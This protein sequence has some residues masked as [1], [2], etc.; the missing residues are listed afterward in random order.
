MTI[1]VTGC[2]VLPDGSYEGLVVDVTEG[3]AVVLSI[4]ITAGERKGDVAEVRS[5]S[6]GDDAGCTLM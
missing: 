5:A 3:D 6:G 2:G 1:R 4:V